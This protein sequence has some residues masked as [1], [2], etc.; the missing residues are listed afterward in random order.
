MTEWEQRIEDA[1]TMTPFIIDSFPRI[2]RLVTGRIE[3]EEKG[4]GQDS[5]NSSG[6]R[7][8]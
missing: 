5:K 1:K 3:D 8:R 7:L 6:V 4:G 2:F